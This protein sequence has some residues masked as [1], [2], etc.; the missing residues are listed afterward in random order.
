[1][2]PLSHQSGVWG[3]GCA[4][5]QGDVCTD[6]AYRKPRLAHYG[7]RRAHVTC[8]TASVHLGDFKC[9]SSFGEAQGCRRCGG[10]VLVNA[11]IGKVESQKSTCPVC[12]AYQA[13][14]PGQVR[15]SL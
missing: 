1:V 3:I 7:S 9:A 15:F 13:L 5:Y 6:C 2:E 10:K 4:N 8:Y 11:E 14:G 12:R